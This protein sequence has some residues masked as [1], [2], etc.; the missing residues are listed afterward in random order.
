MDKS[1]MKRSN[2]SKVSGLRS[3]QIMTILLTRYS[4]TV[5]VY[6]TVDV[7]LSSVNLCVTS[8]LWLTVG[9]YV[10]IFYTNN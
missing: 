2:M 7:C 8:V 6:V 1:R 5:G 4:Y 3:C 10:N 9:T